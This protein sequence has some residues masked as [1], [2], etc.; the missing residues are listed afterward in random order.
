ML[1]EMEF[2][3][4]YSLNL[5]FGKIK[6]EENNISKLMNI[7]IKSRNVGIS[8]LICLFYQSCQ[9]ED[10]KNIWIHNNT[11]TNCYTKEYEAIIK[12][13]IEELQPTD[14]D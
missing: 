3:F 11:F 13:E 14:C 10:K 6:I 5:I 2:S 12:K 9:I 8:K 1:E 7:W 4:I